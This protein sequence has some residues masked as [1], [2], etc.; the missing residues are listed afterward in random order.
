MICP[1]PVRHKPTPQPILLVLSITVMTAYIM[2]KQILTPNCNKHP[3]IVP[4]LAASIAAYPRKK[5]YSGKTP[6]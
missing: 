2:A 1:K 3:N 5:P 6:S 4:I